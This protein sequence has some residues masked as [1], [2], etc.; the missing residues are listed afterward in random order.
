MRQFLIRMRMVLGGAICGSFIG[1]F[2]GALS[3]VAY[4]S[5][6]GNHAYDLLVA[7]GG[8]VVFGLPGALYGALVDP[9]QGRVSDKIRSG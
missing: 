8:G 4:G 1:L 7:L 6:V 9:P 5:H 2:V 3:A